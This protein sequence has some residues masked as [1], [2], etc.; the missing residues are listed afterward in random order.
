MENLNRGFCSTSMDLS[1]SFY[2]F[3]YFIFRKYIWFCGTS[4][5]RSTIFNNCMSSNNYSCST[6]CFFFKNISNRAATI[7]FL[8]IVWLILI[9]LNK[10]LYFIFYLLS[11]YKG[12][13]LF[14][15]C[16]FNVNDFFSLSNVKAIITV[17]II[18]FWIRNNNHNCSIITF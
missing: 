8:I 7:L 14:P 6:Y 18:F 16:S 3:F 17:H 9:G 2:C 11:I 10:F 4:K 13:H 1:Y 15:L 12:K 5:T